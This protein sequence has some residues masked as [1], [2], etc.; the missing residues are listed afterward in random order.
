[1]PRTT[2]VELDIELPSTSRA[3]QLE[4]HLRY[5][6]HIPQVPKYCFWGFR[7][8]DKMEVRQK[9]FRDLFFRNL[10]RNSFFLFLHFQKLTQQNFKEDL[11]TPKKTKKAILTSSKFLHHKIEK[12]FV[13][14]SLVPAKSC[15]LGKCIIQNITPQNLQSSNV[16]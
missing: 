6:L 5:L 7:Q 15:L 4:T 11:L 3:R 1:M 16:G 10:S 12:Y 13:T 14:R 9:S 2:F 8:W